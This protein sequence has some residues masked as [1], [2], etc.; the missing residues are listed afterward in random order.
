MTRLIVFLFTAMLCVSCSYVPKLDSI[1]PDK[2]NEYKKS[3]SLPDLEVPPDLT[4]ES[5]NDSMDIPNEGASLAQYQKSRSG[6]TSP[7]SSGI[8]TS[9]EAGADEQWVMVR[10]KPENIW[11]RLRT[12]MDD[13]GY[14]LELDDAEL[15]VLETGWTDPYLTEGFSYRGKFKIFSEPGAEPGVTVLYL[16]NQQQ[17]LAKKQDGSDSWSDTEKSTSAEQKLAGDLNLYFNGSRDA[18]VQSV[19]AATSQVSTQPSE[20][21]QKALVQTTED[22]KEFLAI[23]AEF[24]RAWRHTEAALERAGLPISGKDIGKGIY[25]VTYFDNS[26]EKRKAGYQNSNSGVMTH[27]TVFLTRLAS[28]VSEIRP[29]WS[30]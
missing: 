3:Q 28:L 16:S 30:Y 21:K 22:G 8:P 14:V 11:P 2:K 23:P 19:P 20:P 6:T 4:A 26:G 7:K 17:L 9:A 5:G 25:F 29:S 15:G 24:T 13:Q 1:I 27:L 10:G 18:I 12:F